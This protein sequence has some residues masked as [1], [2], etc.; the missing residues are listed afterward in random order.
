MTSVN[1]RALQGLKDNPIANLSPGISGWRKRQMKPNLADVKNT[2]TRTTF[3]VSVI[4]ET[5]A[6]CNLS[7]VMC[8]QPNLKRERGAMD[9]KVFS[10][11][12][13]EIALENPATD[14]W[15]ALMG[16]PLIMG[17]KF[18][19]MVRYAKGRGIKNVHLNTN[20]CLLSNHLAS[21]LIAAGVDEIIVGLDAFTEQT[22]KRVRVG[23]DFLQTVANIEFLLDR[24]QALGSLTPKVILQFIVMEENEHEAEAFQRHWLSKNAIVKIRPKLGWGTGVQAD[25]LNLPDSERTFPCSWLTRT[26]SIHWTGRFAQCDADFEGGY[27]PGDIRTQTIKEIW[28]GELARR[29]ERHWAG[30]FGHDLCKNCHDWQAGRSAFYYPE[31]S[32]AL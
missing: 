9:F 16:E 18:I 4:I 31:Q 32:A 10:K 8:P 5:I 14:V 29:R 3:P 12:I 23:G 17:D 28:N 13:D 6:Y 27:S 7:C 2:L 24:R 25:N 19:E 30:D 15:L 1:R 22:Y 20:A 26:V 11:I 21:G